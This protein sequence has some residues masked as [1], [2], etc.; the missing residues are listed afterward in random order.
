[1]HRIVKAQKVIEFGTLSFE[2]PISK[3]KIES[4]SLYF[5]LPHH[6]LPF[7]GAACEM[8]RENSLAN[9]RQGWTLKRNEK[10]FEIFTLEKRIRRQYPAGKSLKIHT[11]PDTYTFEKKFHQLSLNPILFPLW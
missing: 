5:G 2:N 1:M 11:F 8:L 4:F 10:R 7:R 9:F 6:F 3:R